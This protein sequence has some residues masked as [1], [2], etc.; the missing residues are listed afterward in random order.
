MTSKKKKLFIRFLFF[1]IIII[2]ISFIFMIIKSMSSKTIEIKKSFINQEIFTKAFV[3]QQED[4]IYLNGVRDLHLKIKEGD[5]LA[6]DTVIGN[7]EDIQINNQEG[8]DLEIINE[9]LGKGIHQQ[10]GLFDKDLE[11]INK[12]LIDIEFKIKKAKKENAKNK[13]EKLKK[14]KENLQDK[15]QIIET[16]FRY[17]FTDNESL[18]KIKNKLQNDFKPIEGQITPRKLGIHYSSY[19]FFQQDGFENLL[20]KDLLGKITPQYFNQVERYMDKEKNLIKEDKNIF[21][22]IDG[23]EIYLVIKVPQ[24]S[25]VSMEEKLAKTKKIV[26]SQWKKSGQTNFYSYI[27]NR[28]DILEKFPKITLK[29]DNNSIIGYILDSNKNHDNKE[30]ILTIKVETKNHKLIGK[31]QNNI[32]VYDKQYQGFIIPKKSIIRENGKEG[33]I[34]LKENNKEQFIEINIK[35]ELEDVAIL[36]PGENKKLK[37]G[38]RILANP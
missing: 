8:R 38:I 11:K 14:E 32:Y 36:E 25:F 21:K 3:I 9:K 28:R 34:L 6:V 29:W 19:I 31:R 33:V 18:N 13:I 4:I 2:F 12:Q 10:N 27:E 37:N 16:S 5:K 23:S 22:F 1:F 24:N 20:H 7:F 17:T 30:K 35:S 15:K 26:N